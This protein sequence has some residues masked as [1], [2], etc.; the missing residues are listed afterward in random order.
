MTK[1]QTTVITVLSI[2]AFILALL[3]CGRY[4]LRLDFTR[5]KAHTI[6]K[7]SRNIHLELPDPVNITYYLSDKLRTVDPGPGEIEDTLREYVSYSKGKI[8]LAV[9]DPVR[10]GETAAAEEMGI[11]PRQVNTVEKDQASFI[12][13]YSGVVIEYLD[14]IEVL[15]WI[16]TTNTLEY[17]LTSRI[18]SMVRGTQRRIGAL[19]GD[20]YRQ[21]N[22]DFRYT[23]RILSEAG[24]NVRVIYPGEEIPDNL[25]AL[26]VF[27]GSEYMDE[28][29]LYR[30]DRYIQQGGKVLFA[31]DGVFVDLFTGSLEA[32]SLNDFTLIDMIASYGAIIKP[33]LALDRSA[34]AMQY[35]SATPF[36]AVQRITRYPLWI[37]VTEENGNPQHPITSYFYGLDLFWA[38]PLELHELAGVETSVLFTSTDEAWSMRQEFYTS[39]DIPYMLEIE[40]PDTTGTKILGASLTGTFPSFFRGSPKPVREGSDEELPDL[41]D[42]ASPSR[43]IVIGDTDF[44]SDII[45]STQAVQNLDFILRAADWLANDDDIIGIR[46][47]QPQSGRLDKITDPS[48]RAAAAGFSRIVNVFVIPLLVVGA[49]LFL[50]YRRRKRSRGESR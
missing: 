10:T 2:A 48:A 12:T 8:A 43:I 6:S 23:N 19:I 50:A 13:V 30:I 35:Q 33:E 22:E 26:L 42:R 18:R 39:P 14:K 27:A 36:G 47:R 46:N 25:P 24:F 40:A 31:V 45:V 7:V 41:P 37:G 5:H 29:A 38:S 4:W 21:W 3:V 11:Q 1:K 20:D 9:K 15:P 28:W 32:R 16:I 44:A 34:L 49:G 17:D